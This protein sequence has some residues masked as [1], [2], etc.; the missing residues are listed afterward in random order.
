MDLHPLGP[1]ASLNVITWDLMSKAHRQTSLE[2]SVELA[3]RD[4]ILRGRRDRLEWIL[5][6]DA[7][8]MIEPGVSSEI[9][10]TEIGI[11]IYQTQDAQM[12]LNLCK[13]CEIDTQQNK[14]IAIQQIR[15]TDTQSTWLFEDES[16]SSPGHDVLII[17]QQEINTNWRYYFMLA[18]LDCWVYSLNTQYPRYGPSH[19]R[20]NGLYSAPRPFSPSTHWVITNTAQGIGFKFITWERNEQILREVVPEISEKEAL[21]QLAGTQREYLD[22]GCPRL[23]VH[24]QRSTSWPWFGNNRFLIIPG[25]KTIKVYCFD[26]SFVLPN[27]DLS[28]RREREEKAEARKAERL[29]GLRPLDNRRGCPVASSCS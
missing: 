6:Y 14:V 18:S 24:L 4:D 21:A 5:G 11:S 17:P 19:R 27:E 28:Y 16:L 29:H 15:I 1:T 2:I 10:L 20:G 22:N 8:H 26:R 23:E 3:T 7:I 9:C 12:S 13:V 25:Y